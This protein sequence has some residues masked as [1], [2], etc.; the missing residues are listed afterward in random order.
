MIELIASII[1][2]VS[3]LGMSA[4]AIRKIPVLKGLGVQEKTGP[5]FFVTVKE[6]VKNTFVSKSKKLATTDF[7]D[8]LLQ[9][10]VSKVKVLSLK[11]E[12]RCNRLLEKTRERSKRQKED[13]K[14][15][16]KISKVS[17][18]KKK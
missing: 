4:I 7:W 5:G 6:K 16:D 17:L 1:L 13:T 14:Y 18:K 3:F 11:I 15:W 10:I 9:K 12:V 2:L 8:V